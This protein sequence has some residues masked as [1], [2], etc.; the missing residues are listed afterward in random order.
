M[1]TIFMDP[2]APAPLGQ[3]LRRGTKVAGYEPHPG[4]LWINNHIAQLPSNEWVA[5]DAAGL[6]AHDATMDGLMLKLQ[7]S[8]VAIADVAVAYNG[9]E[10]L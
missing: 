9:I 7:Q 4:T 8:H 1:S 6:V 3:D 2:P 5:A 10:P